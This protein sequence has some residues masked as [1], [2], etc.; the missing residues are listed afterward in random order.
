MEYEIREWL[1]Y[2]KVGVDYCTPFSNKKSSLDQYL[3]FLS[4]RRY[5]GATG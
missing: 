3:G 1:Y 2:S 5:T 4:E